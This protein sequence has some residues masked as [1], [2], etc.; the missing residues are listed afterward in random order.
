MKVILIHN[1]ICT[2]FGDGGDCCQWSWT[3]LGMP[4]TNNENKT[5]GRV[6]KNDLDKT[7][8]GKNLDGRYSIYFDREG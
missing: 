5:N 1:T 2:K 4:F 7:F 8:P 6:L 3:L